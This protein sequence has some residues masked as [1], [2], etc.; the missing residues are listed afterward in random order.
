[1]GED[2]ET[3]LTAVLDG[4]SLVLKRRPDVSMRL[5]PLYKD[6]FSGSICTVIFRRDAAGSVSALSVVQDRVWDMRFVRRDVT[7]TARQ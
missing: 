5:T 1:V 6:A 2:A 3:T 4:T 7:T